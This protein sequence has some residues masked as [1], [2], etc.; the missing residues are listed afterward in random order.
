[1]NLHAPIRYSFP[2]VE[3]TVAD[4]SSEPPSLGVRQSRRVA[5]VLLMRNVRLRIV[6]NSSFAIVKPQRA[7]EQ[8]GDAIRKDERRKDSKRHREPLSS[9]IVENSPVSM[10]WNREVHAKNDIRFSKVLILVNV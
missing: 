7:A 6:T 2:H 1:M 8:L 10:L 4:S 5:A 9:D 3:T